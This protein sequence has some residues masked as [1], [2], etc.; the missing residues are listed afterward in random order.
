MRLRSA[1]PLLLLLAAS[2]AWAASYQVGPTRPHATLNALFAAVDLAG[3]DVVEIEG[4]VTYAGGVIVPQADGGSP[5][6]PVVFRGL[7]ANGQRP[8]VTVAP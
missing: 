4:G 5:G 3:G 1:L 2:C 7:R 6:N 8:T